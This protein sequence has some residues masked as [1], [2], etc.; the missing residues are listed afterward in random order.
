VEHGADRIGHGV[1]ATR[2]KSLMA[3]LAR[4][5]VT[6]EVCPTSYPPFGVEADLHTLRGNGV[7]VA[8]GA[9]DPVL[10][11]C[12]LADQYRIARDTM[13][14]DDAA[15]AELARASIRACA[16]PDKTA[17]LSQVDAWL[18]AAG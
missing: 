12:G 1:T 15:L 16:A 8:L 14:L 4:N 2:D 17:R 3:E 6:L 9:D 18:A 5:G 13:G 11:G 10:F 7:A